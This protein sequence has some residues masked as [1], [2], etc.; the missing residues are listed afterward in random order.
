MLYAYFSEGGA[1]NPALLP[2]EHVV[3]F[4]EYLG[5][6]CSASMY[7]IYGV[8]AQHSPPW[9]C[10][11]SPPPTLV[12]LITLFVSSTL[13]TDACVRPIPTTGTCIALCFNGSTVGGG[14]PN[15]FPMRAFQLSSTTAMTLFKRY[16]CTRF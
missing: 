7:T 2:S 13:Q 16:T 3:M 4:N 15:V 11:G 5:A 8:Y 12:P 14:C 10:F 1:R 6:V 9:Q